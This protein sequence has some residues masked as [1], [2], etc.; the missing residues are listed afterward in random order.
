MDK[1]QNHRMGFLN[2][3]VMHKKSVM[4]LQNDHNQGFENLKHSNL[5]NQMNKSTQNKKEIISMVDEKKKQ[6]MLIQ[7]MNQIRLLNLSHKQKSDISRQ[8]YN[9]TIDVKSLDHRNNSN[10]SRQNYEQIINVKSLD[11]RNNS[12]FS[13]QNYEQTIN[14][15]NL[16]HQNRTNY[17]KQ[18]YLQMKNLKEQEYSNSS[19]LSI[20]NHNQISRYSRQGYLQAKDLKNQEYVNDKDKIQTMLVGQRKN[21]AYN[22]LLELDKMYK[23]FNYQNQLKRQVNENRMNEI[24]VLYDRKEE[25]NKSEHKKMKDEM[26]YKKNL[27]NMKYKQA[28]SLQNQQFL[29]NKD[30]IINEQEEKRQTEKERFIQQKELEEQRFKRK[31]YLSNLDAI[32]TN[33]PSFDIE[34][35]IYRE[36]YIKKIKEKF[37]LNKKLNWNSQNQIASIY[38]FRG[39]GKSVLALTYAYQSFENPYEMIWWINAENEETIKNNLKEIA[40]QLGMSSAYNDC[41]INILNYIKIKISQNKGKWLIIYDNAE[42][43]DLF[44]IYKSS[45]QFYP[46]MGGH[47]LITSRN[48]EA[49]SPIYLNKLNQKEAIQL[50]ESIKKPKNSE[51]YHYMEDLIFKYDKLP[52]AI[53]QSCKYMKKIS[54]GYDKYMKRKYFL[55]DKSHKPVKNYNRKLLLSKTLTQKIDEIGKELEEVNI[56]ANF[57]SFIN[58]NN[59]P[60]YLLEHLIINYEELDEAIGYLVELGTLQKTKEDYFKLHPVQQSILFNRLSKDEKLNTIKKASKVIQEA[61]INNS[62]EHKILIPHLYYL[63]N[64]L[65]KELH[66]F[67]KGKK[68]I[69]LKIDDDEKRNDNYKNKYYEQYQKLSEEMLPFINQ[70]SQYLLKLREIKASFQI[71]TYSLLVTQ[72]SKNKL[73]IESD[74]YNSYANLLNFCN[75]K[76][77][78]IKY[79]EK[80]IKPLN[81]CLLNSSSFQNQDGNK[82]KFQ[83]F[84]YYKDLGK[85][86]IKNKENKK[87]KITLQKC[88]ELDIKEDCLESAD[89]LFQLGF[90]YFKEKDYKSSIE[91]FKKALPIYIKYNSYQ[92]AAYINHILGKSYYELNTKSSTNIN[93][94][95]NYHK[96]AHYIFNI[97]NN[98]KGIIEST[99]SLGDICYNKKE[100]KKAIDKYE[101]GWLKCIESFD[102]ND[103]FMQYIWKNLNEGY[104]KLCES[105]KIS[106]LQLAVKRGNAIT[107]QQMIFDL[108]S[109]PSKEKEY[110]INNQFRNYI[111]KFSNYVP[112]DVI[113]L[114]S[115]YYGPYLNYIDDKGHSLLHNAENEETIIVLKNNG[116]N[117]DVQD[118]NKQTAYQLHQKNKSGLDKILLDLGAKKWGKGTGKFKELKGHIKNITDMAFHPQRNIFASA[119]SDKKVIF[120]DEIKNCNS[121]IFEY[122]HIVNSIDFDFENDIFAF[123]YKRFIDIY[124][125]NNYKKTMTLN[126]NPY[127]INDITFLKSNKLISTDSEDYINLWDIEKGIIEKNIKVKANNNILGINDIKYDYVRKMLVSAHSDKTIKF[128]DFRLKNN[129]IKSLR[130]HYGEVTDLAFNKYFSILASASEDNT[131]QLWDI[132]SLG[133]SIKLKRHE[134]YVSSVSFSLKQTNILASCS[135]NNNIFFWDTD[136]NIYIDCLE[137][138]SHFKN[139]YSIQKI[140]FSPNNNNL[141]LSTN[142]GFINIWDTPRKY[143]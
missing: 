35:L 96:E 16:D 81:N 44:E 137:F 127:K 28:T 32:K 138:A 9:Q 75:N 66:F 37:G 85:C 135:R 54:I 92:E 42:D 128:W 123:A 2:Q 33:L 29:Q 51:E 125:A 101:V 27:Q 107:L 139:N 106:K 34:P 82:I 56:I 23:N 91:N 122:K 31:L 142:T 99:M 43:L 136:N 19:N 119:S 120:W 126:K 50:C 87:A 72:N 55:R 111:N 143:S 74:I 12:N 47:I 105:E 130:K 24:N 77:E 114:I 70:L 104:G 57:I 18:S 67:D 121:K 93:I 76:S 3:T 110:I 95:E 14:V 30:L 84:K 61:W 100:Y 73:S 103:P 69:Q 133:K 64:H 46:S 102:I 88:L 53:V 62:E 89:L 25:L 116:I 1:S 65:I 141:I 39:I 36:E 13:R 115:K 8:N 118:Y 124:D 78:A 5:M 41:E 52:L 86:L 26:E 4:N 20:Q 7:Q 63:W 11:H 129:L 21:A 45:K 60:R 59:I 68:I 94:S 117:L 58:S 15:K 109:H 79:Y 80:A 22:H 71:L 90:I 131:V 132:K 83:L 113:Y 140:S 6:N 48:S 17:S 98:N 112:N 10:F 134:S 97:L 49:P 38:G 40:S 108:S